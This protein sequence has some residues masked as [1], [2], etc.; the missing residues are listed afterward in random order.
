[1]AS[2]SVSSQHKSPPLS[3]ADRAKKA[4]NIKSPISHRSNA[5]SLP[6]PATTK[7]VL[8]PHAPSSSAP[9]STS[10]PVDVSHPQHGPPTAA[11]AS[12][13]AAAQTG[14]STDLKTPESAKRPSADLAAKALSIVAAHTADRKVPVV[15]IWNLRMEQRAA[16]HAKPDLGSQ[17]QPPAS[18]TSPAS[19]KSSLP[20]DRLPPKSSSSK[21]PL[22]SAPKTV[23]GPSA[24]HAV[25]G[26]T[27]LAAPPQTDIETWP[28]VGKSLTPTTAT[29][30]KKESENGVAKGSDGDST[31]ANTSTSRKS[32]K[33]KWIQ[34][35]PEELQ[36]AADAHNKA[37]RPRQHSRS[38]KS[39]TR[40][41]AKTY[42]NTQGSS[43]SSASAQGPSRIQSASQSRT[44]SRSESVQSSPHFPRGRRLPGDNAVTGVNGVEGYERNHNGVPRSGAS[45]PLLQVQPHL[46]PPPQPIPPAEPE[47][48]PMYTNNDA[49]S[50]MMGNMACPIPIYSHGHVQ[51]QTNGALL[52]RYAHPHPPISPHGPHPP[53]V[54]LGMLP[55]PPPPGYHHS[56]AG[57]PPLPP[58][59]SYPKPTLDPRHS[60]DPS[61][62]GGRKGDCHRCGKVGHNSRTCTEAPVA[63]NSYGGGFNA[64]YPYSAYPMYPYDYTSPGMTPQP[65]GYWSGHPSQPGSGRH[66][67][68]YPP[69][70]PH[71]GAALPHAHPP[72]QPPQPRQTGPT[73]E[74]KRSKGFS[75]NVNAAEDNAFVV[76]MP[77]RPPPPDKSSPVA[78][79]FPTAAAIV[80][81][82]AA[83]GD[84]DTEENIDGARRAGDA[85]AGVVFGSIGVPGSSA[86]PSPTLLPA[87]KGG[88]EGDGADGEEKPFTKFSIGFGP[89]DVGP[90]ARSRSRT[91]SASHSHSRKR[92]RTTTVED[93]LAEVKEDSGI[94]GNAAVKVIDLTDAIKDIKEAKWEFGT[95]TSTTAATSVHSDEAYSPRDVDSVAAGATEGGGAEDMER[96]AHDTEP[97]QPILPSIA[98]F[99]SPLH[100]GLAST[101]SSPSQLQLRLQQLSLSGHTPVDE[102]ADDADDAEAFK[103]K[104]YGYGFGSGS[105]GSISPPDLQEGPRQDEEK[106]SVVSLPERDPRHKENRDM[107]VPVRPKRGGGYHGGYVQEPRGGYER[108]EGRGHGR[109]GRGM[110]GF[111]RGYSRRGAA[112]YQPPPPRQ[113]PPFSV[114]PPAMH[115][116]PMVMAD[117]TSGFYS[118]RPSMMPPYFPPGYETYIPPVPA[119]APPAP[120]VPVPISPLSF[121][122]DPTRYYL[123]GQLEYYLSPQN[124]AQDFFLRQRMDSRGWVP[125][126]LIASFNRVR[127]LTMDTQLV[128]DVLLLS[129]VVQ[130]KDE[131]VRMVSWQQF[132]LP[133][134]APSTIEPWEEPRDRA[135]HGQQSRQEAEDAVREKQGEGDADADADAEVDAEVDDDDEEDVVFVMNREEGSVQ[136]SPERRM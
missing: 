37:S 76:R 108:G 74:R 72:Q 58:L 10:N 28:E 21:I 53:Y 84:V 8:S 85:L 30:S 83:A 42:N 78:G 106:T 41:S 36:A 81:F 63:G 119:A 92:S 55:H 129:S 113:P 40:R 114:T 130:V 93:G 56:P 97:L 109:R 127:Q 65:Y 91:Q 48:A 50:A 31:S 99:D 22:D 57:N 27:P 49:A 111:G 11:P 14:Q 115:F 5:Q 25:N 105:R 80:S 4:Q 90:P 13:P 17:S 103:V 98:G 95:A 68:V 126:S 104:D 1:M 26:V 102:E 133:D 33:T 18:Q 16:A 19:S 110:N 38:T 23:H 135:Y 136:W 67:P 79:Y 7:A 82:P 94:G 107:E 29:E 62:V 45:S 101:G 35:P 52:P 15:N 116:P 60:L 122:L 24:G 71:Y 66:S 125:I 120:P 86:C 124:M 88:R 59:A 89:E 39:Q 47:Q 77:P 64:N 51:P 3:Y 134:A 73:Q 54:P 87:T 44:H 131:W 128:R 96:K 132:V 75:T 121:P 12:P 6:P 34:I 9:K 32:E 61:D 20:A 123:L 2:P 100:T 43:S 69:P 70:Q 46:Q 117:M 112:G 118:S